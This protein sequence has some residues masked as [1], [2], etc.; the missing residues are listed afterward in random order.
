M[1]KEA[2]SKLTVKTYGYIRGSNDKVKKSNQRKAISA[3]AKK[4]NLKIEFVEETIS[5][6]KNIKERSILKLIDRCNSGDKILVSEVARLAR[7]IRELLEISN[8]CQEKEISL[9]ILNPPMKL[10]GTAASNALLAVLGIVA[11]ME[12]E[13]MSDRIKQSLAGKKSDIESKG[14]F[15][16]K[17]GDHCKALGTPKG[18]KQKLALESKKNQVLEYY[19]L[20]LSMARM[21][22]VL[23]VSR[24]TVKKFLER[25]P[26][27]DGAYQD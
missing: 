25:F 15:V 6:T 21:A 11:E 16:N 9:E 10:D 7:N 20:G 8:S 19:N 2:K 4:R 26:I 18:G 3:V 22:K 12:K 27:V 1:S 24:H 23:E 17:N 13:S 14:Y 5:A